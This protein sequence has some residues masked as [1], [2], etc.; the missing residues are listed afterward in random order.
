MSGTGLGLYL[1]RLIVEKHGG[2]ISAESKEG[3]GF[4][5]SFRLPLEEEKS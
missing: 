1:S 4:K 2:T 3:E 5:I